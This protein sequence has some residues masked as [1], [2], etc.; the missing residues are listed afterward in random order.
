MGPGRRGSTPTT[1]WSRPTRRCG[2][3]TSGGCG[4][5]ASPGPGAGVP[6]RAGGRGRGRRAGRGRGRQG[7]VAG[8]PRPAGPAVLRAGGAAVAVRPAGPRPQA[9]ARAVRVRLPAGD[10]QAGRQAPLGV[11]RAADPVRRPA[12][13]QARRH[14]R[15]QGRGAAGRRDPRG[16]AVHQGD[17]RRRATARS[18]TWPA[19]S[20]WTSRCPV[21]RA[22]GSGPGAEG[23]GVGRGAGGRWLLE[24]DEDGVA[25]GGADVLAGVLLGADPADLAGREVD[26]G[27]AAVA[28]VEA[29]PEGAAG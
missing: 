11:L 27:L 2:S 29:A 23:W 3:A 26:V 8:R 16:R 21:E 18:R 1:R 12:G 22:R 20:S 17:D 14:R 4:R 24:L 25:L 28:A 9:D 10:V 15:P 6:G 19:G 5:W 13:R 7:H